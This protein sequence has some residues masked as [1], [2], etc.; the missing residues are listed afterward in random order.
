MDLA[1]SVQALYSQLCACSIA[2]KN[3]SNFLASH[4]IFGSFV[5]CINVLAQRL[6]AAPWGSDYKLN[7]L[8]YS[9]ITEQHTYEVVIIY[10]DMFNET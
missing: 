5:A 4:K 6:T 1:A 8:T 7:K 9:V 2:E 10:S 3:R